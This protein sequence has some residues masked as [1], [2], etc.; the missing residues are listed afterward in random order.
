MVVTAASLSPNELE[1][2]T[3]ATGRRRN[4]LGQLHEET[5]KREHSSSL[6]PLPAFADSREIILPYRQQVPRETWGHL[7]NRKPP[8]LRSQGGHESDDLDSLKIV[9]GS[10]AVQCYSRYPIVPPQ[11]IRPAGSRLALEKFKAEIR[12]RYP[13]YLS[14]GTESRLLYKMAIDTGDWWLLENL[15][16][17]T[18]INLS[19]DDNGQTPLLYAAGLDKDHAAG[20]ISFLIGEGANV[21]AVDSKG[22]SPL[23]AAVTKSNLERKFSI[24][25]D[26]VVSLVHD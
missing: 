17:W 8:Q 12:S 15:Q 23:M 20:M 10:G 6:R 1:S 14:E 13:D 19:L 9:I 25:E 18:Y 16:V 7:S 2:L 11:G 24:T 4:W 5:T 21:N 3:D 26:I 22:L